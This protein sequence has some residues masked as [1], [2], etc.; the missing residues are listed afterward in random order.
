MQKEDMRAPSQGQINHIL[1]VMDDDLWLSNV[2]D[3]IRHY[4][5]AGIDGI[6]PVEPRFDLDQQSPG[7]F[8]N[9]AKSRKNIVYV[10]T[11]ENRSNFELIV[12]QYAQPQNYFLIEG[13]DNKSIIA[14]FLKNKDSI[15]QQFHKQEI[16]DI[17]KRIKEGP[18]FETVY[19][20]DKYNIDIDL[21]TSYKRVLVDDNFVWYKKEIASGNNNILVY[22]LPFQLV[23]PF[24]TQRD[25]ILDMDYLRDSVVGK[26]IH[27]SEPDTFMNM[28]VDF[29]PFYR[30]IYIKNQE[31][32]EVKGTWDME[33]SFMGGPYLSYIVKKDDYY[34]I[35]E[36]FTYNP[37]MSKRDVML[38]L[39]A[40]M[41][42]LKVFK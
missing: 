4:L 11:N 40:I 9:T 30:T 3:S 16:A 28:S 29:E 31:I 13:T 12:D 39:E 18:L 14:T 17:Q 21:P 34:L 2:G 42:T 24:K 5:A 36:G 37:S 35:I 41:G 32:T 6:T 27:S 23:K 38:E 10:S 7:I 33:N 26:Y 25:F 8:A 15:I 1:L 19:L 20:H 22:S